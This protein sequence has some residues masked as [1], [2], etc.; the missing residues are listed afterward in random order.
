MKLYVNLKNCYG[1]NSF[2]HT[3]DFGNVPKVNKSYSIY[4]PNGTMKSSFARTFLNISKNEDPKE[5]RFGKISEYTATVDGER[6][7]NDEIYV[8]KSE[9]DIKEESSGVTDILVNPEKKA[10]YDQIILELAK[11]KSNAINK[12]SSVTG[13][14]RKDIEFKI[15]EDLGVNSIEDFFSSVEGK[16]FSPDF[17]NFKYITIFDKNAI[18]V[19]QSQEFLENSR[20]FTKRYE[21]VF[22]E[23]NTIYKKGVFN[24]AKAD[25]SVKTL[26]T[27]GFFDCGHKV[28]IEGDEAPI[29]SHELEERIVAINSV[30]DNDEVLKNI[31]SSLAKNAEAK[32]LT[33]LIE[34]LSSSHLEFFLEK[35]KKENIEEFKKDIWRY[36]AFI[37]PEV[38]KYSDAHN[39]FKDELKSIEEDA[40]TIA[41][42]WANA[43]KKFNDRFVKMPFTLAVSNLQKAALGL[44][45]AK[46]KF[47]FKDENNNVKEFSI[48]EVKTL[49]QGEKRALYL[50]NFIFDVEARIA[51]GKR[52][53]FIIDDVADSFDYK[54]KHAIIEYLKDLD[55]TENLY[56]IILT[57]NFDFFRS[58][59]VFV[60]RKKCLMTS[61]TP[62]GILLSIAHGVENYFK[63]IFQKKIGQSD[64]VL[65][66]TI[67]FTRNI[68]EYTKGESNEDYLKLT[69]LLH[70]KKSSATLTKT[71][72]F[73][74]YNP[75]FSSEHQGG[76]RTILS[77]LFGEADAIAVEPDNHGLNLEDK[78]LLSI[79]IR[80]RAE[81][82][83]INEI[84]RINNDHEYWCEEY[85]QFGYLIQEYSRLS[86]GSSNI[87]TLEKIGIAVNS[88]IHLNSFMYEP[89][90]DLSIDYLVELYKEVCAFAVAE[91]QEVTAA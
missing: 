25:A 16:I 52:T 39:Q 64:R 66:A 4:A 44:E 89:I 74:I 22:L 24:P 48:D 5:E 8:V 13:I 81:Q 14:A 34:A 76:D 37:T 31:K 63:G 19:I 45:K 12:L 62:A 28:F 17:G 85:S 32:A 60:S 68:I 3:F 87:K 2:E 70:W 49:S 80:L 7:S 69:N 91:Q 65:C 18:S 51:S 77:I 11:A 72:F 56:Q 38:K 10:R 21:A 73:N 36:S 53:F 35:I 84:R 67:P 83:L 82:Y 1:I 47:I 23:K 40:A 33:E 29:G 15:K 42:R 58:I 41:P 88:N 55:Q 43:V 86:P 20:E 6:I 71:D 57:H 9:I 59:T 50:L 30:I 78:I 27:N 90:L 26:K 79:A 46:L 61:K 75:L 54:N